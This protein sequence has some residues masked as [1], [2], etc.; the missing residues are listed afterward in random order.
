MQL[1]LKKNGNGNAHGNGGGRGNAL[2]IA[3]LVVAVAL[4]GFLIYRL[5]GRLGG[6]A[7]EVW[8]A[9]SPLE[10]GSVVGA[11]D[12][13][14][15]TLRGRPVPEGAVT[16]RSQIEG[17]RLTRPLAAGEPFVGGALARPQR[18]QE[19]ARS[20][21]EML[22]PGRVLTRVL[23]DIDSVLMSELEFG[24]RFE[25]VA[26]GGTSVPEQPA[27]RVVASD[28]FFFAWVD[29]GLLAAGGGG[30]GS[31]QPQQEGLLANLL[32]TPV[33]E[34]GGGPRATSSTKLLV[35]LEPEDVLPVTEAAAA[36]SRLSMVLHGRREVAEG[37]MMT[38]PSARPVVVELIDGNR[39]EKVPFV[40]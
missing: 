37:R 17:R 3:L 4:A 38:L 21:T 26:S 7:T 9:R 10:A 11:G 29:P 27:A 31:Q 28:V 20:L 22:P 18:A 16:D 12:L 6:P 5:A 35:A 8:V 24:D 30:N 2:K 1:K 33:L 34:R 32:A 19:Q 25:I 15:V 14:A 36:G 13:E 23:I 40:Q 39:R